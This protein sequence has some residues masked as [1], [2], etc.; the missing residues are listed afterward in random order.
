M[1][2]TEQIQVM[3]EYMTLSKR[4]KWYM[5]NENTNLFLQSLENNLLQQMKI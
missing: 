2:L 5:T 4:T 3:S 1:N